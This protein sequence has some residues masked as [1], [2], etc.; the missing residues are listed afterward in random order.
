MNVLIILIQKYA[1][2]NVI[3]LIFISDAYAVYTDVFTFLPWINSVLT[4]RIELTN[5]I[6]LFFQNY[7][8]KYFF[9]RNLL[10]LTALQQLHPALVTALAM[11]T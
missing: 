10:G 2:Q 8:Q 11:L 6:I 5:L 3:F 7:L 1:V 4:V 9:I